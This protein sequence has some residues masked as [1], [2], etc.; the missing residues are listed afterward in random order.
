[1][2][3]QW[4]DGRF[5]DPSWLAR[6]PGDCLYAASSDA[7]GATTGCVNEFTLAHDGLH[8]KARHETGGDEPCHLGFSPDGRYLGVANYGSGSLALFEVGGAGLTARVQLLTHHGHGLHPI[9]QSSPHIHQLVWLPGLPGYCCAVD[10]G[11]DAL[12]VYRQDARTGLLWEQYRLG[13][14]PGEG[15]RHLGFAADGRGWL[16]T[17]LG[18]R[19]FPVRFGREGGKIGE[20]HWQNVKSSATLRRKCFQ[21]G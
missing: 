16:V 4:N 15:P 14:Q 20:G 19:V 8:L 11:L 6:G 1:M 7:Q 9:R 21:W 2:T 18:N 17:E 3:V 13:T 10:L 5:T 12:V